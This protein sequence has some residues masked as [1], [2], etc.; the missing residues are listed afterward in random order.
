MQSM[1]QKKPIND[2]NGLTD[3]AIKTFNYSEKTIKLHLSSINYLL[4][5]ISFVSSVKSMI[6]AMNLML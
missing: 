5:F 4:H 3:D 1:R 2:C 6:P